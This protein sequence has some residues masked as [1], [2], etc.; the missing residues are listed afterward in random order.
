MIA[1]RRKICILTLAIT[2]MCSGA[3][4][5]APEEDELALV[6]GDSSTVSIATGTAQPISQAP[7]QATVITAEQIAASGATDLSQVLETVPGLH[8]NRS[9]TINDPQY[10]IRGIGSQYNPEVL[11]M[12]NGIPLTV[13]FVGDRGQVWAGMPVENIARIE[14]IRGPGSALYGADAFSG[15]IN[16]VTKS[17]SDIDGTQFGLRYGSFDTWDAWALHGGKM[18]AFDVAGYLRVGHTDGFNGNIPV[19]A[20]TG[21]DA[22]FHTHDSLAPGPGYFGYDALDAQIDVAHDK[23]RWRA[24][25]KDR[26]NV[27]WGYGLAQ[28]L[29]PAGQASQNRLTSDLTWHDKDFA[30]NWDVSVQ[31]SYSRFSEESYAVLFPP[32]AFGSF[33]DGMIGEPGHREA[34]MGLNTSAFYSGFQNHRVRLGVGYEN[35]NL[36]R[37][38]E[39]KNFNFVYVPN[40]GNVPSYLGSIVDGAVS[41]IIFLRPHQRTDYFEFLQDE[42]TVA[43]DWHLTVGVR[44]DD[45]S[46]FGATTN[47][48]AALV[49]DASYDITVKLLAGRAFRA[50]S[51]V[52]RYAINNP[53]AIGNP[54]LKPETIDSREL[55]VSWKP[56]A[57]LQLGVSVYHY[58]IRDL[59]QYLDNPD[60]TTGATAQNTNGQAGSGVELEANW[61]VTKQVRL[62]GNYAFQHSIDDATGLDAGMSPHQH[63]NASADWR[64]H[65]DWA[66]NA[67][68]NLVADRERQPG[69]PRPPVPNYRTVDLSLRTGTPS[70]GKWDFRVAI[71]NLFNASVIEPSPVGAPFDLPQM[72]RSLSA[73]LRYSL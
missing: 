31:A 25:F 61:D 69:D 11:M 59:I 12:I 17:A 72:G 51:F 24:S 66:V 29:Y 60:P 41:N 28:S 30:K 4:L 15:V 26:T 21:L 23:W 63:L 73:Q 67:Q 71:H 2:S 14:V 40:V 13:A 43:N 3:A 9:L 55:D 1:S 65:A 33:P 54:N 53:V 52:E 32:G 47:P 5:A 37:T 19:D 45:Y 7:A 48:R 70:A 64:F 27:Q 16:I 62:S 46:D 44:H 68:F 38:T 22:I 50:P 20:Q 18:G 8:I 6:Y 56:R 34:D 36:Y 58:Q 35:Q 49:W 10:M 42:W 39:F 57:D